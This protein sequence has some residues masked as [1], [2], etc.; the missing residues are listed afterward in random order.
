MQEEGP[1]EDEETV[2]INNVRSSVAEA[3]GAAHPADMRRL[4]GSDTAATGNSGNESRTVNHFD[5]VDE[6]WESDSDSD[7]H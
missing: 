3:R 2:Q 5:A 6:Y 4:L 7:F 1:T